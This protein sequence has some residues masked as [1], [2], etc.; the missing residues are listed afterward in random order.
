MLVYFELNMNSSIEELEIA[1]G[2]KKMLIDAK[3]Q[4]C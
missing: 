2:L 3:E 4:F 1:P